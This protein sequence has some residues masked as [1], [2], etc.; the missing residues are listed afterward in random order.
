MTGTVMHECSRLPEQ[1]N[2]HR[3]DCLSSGIGLVKRL[4]LCFWV[5][6]LT[7]VLGV[8]RIVAVILQTGTGLERCD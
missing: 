3:H 5:D 8:S 6:I 4:S 7:A 1:V 2:P